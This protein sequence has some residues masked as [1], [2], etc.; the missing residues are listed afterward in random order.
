MKNML[1][2]YSNSIQDLKDNAKRLLS[3]E[4][5]QKLTSLLEIDEKEINVVF[6]GQYSAGKSSI[7]KMLTGIDEIEIGAGITTQNATKYRL[8]DTTNIIDTPGI[9]TQ[10]R[11][12]HDEITYKEIANADMLVFVITNELFDS[13]LAN[14]FRKL[15]IDND[16][17][18]EMILVVNKMERTA[19]GNCAEQQKI[20][21]DALQDVIY[22]YNSDNLKIAFLDAE[23]YLDSIEEEDEETKIELMERSGYREFLEML[24]DFI[25]SKK[26]VSKLTT[27]LYKM[28]EFMELLL[29]NNLPNSSIESIDAL[30]EELRQQKRLFVETRN[31]LKSIINSEFV[32]AASSIRRMG[33]EATEI[34]YQGCEEE[35]VD[36]ELSNYST[37]IN[38]LFMDTQNNAISIYNEK[39]QELEQDIEDLENIEFSLNLKSNLID[40]FDKLPENVK[41]VI[42]QCCGYAQNGGTKVVEKAFVDSGRKMTSSG[43]MK[44]TNFN[45]SQIHEAVLKVGEKIGYKFKPWQAIKITKGIAIA[46]Q[47]LAVF[48]VFLNVAM[49]VK[50]DIDDH[51]IRELI[52]E[53]RRTIRSQFNDA[54]KQLEHIGNEFI[55]QYVEKRFVTY[56]SS[57]DDRIKIL[58]EDKASTDEYCNT[59]VIL[60]NE[61]SEL[62]KRIHKEL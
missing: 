14:H 35:T 50:G 48:G 40:N 2:E 33:Q 55:D 29:K 31:S 52:S 49:Q 32:N 45:G 20:V 38:S 27:P 43:S 62:I 58:T 34:I 19:K 59:I 53:N 54:A 28:E 10:L 51:K 13:N 18:S 22:P 9:H 60:K 4:D 3:V 46:G 21:L 36:T 16:K 15:A 8:N 1:I 24:N 42:Q 23:S 11:P 6:A 39:L 56:I 25:S 47:A 44:L 30:E 12:D 57:I 17:A 61:C 37:K 26:I 7:A 5:F 41:N